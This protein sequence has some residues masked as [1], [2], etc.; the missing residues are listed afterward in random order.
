MTKNIRK[1]FKNIYSQELAILERKSLDIIKSSKH[2]DMPRWRNL[3]DEL[4]DV[5]PSFFELDGNVIKIGQRDEIDDVSYAKLYEILR[6]YMPWRK[7][8]YSIFGINID[9]EWRSDIK[10]DRFKDGISDISG[11]KILDIGAANGYHSLRALGAGAEFVMGVDPTL[12]Y[13]MQFQLL[14]RYLKSD[15]VNVLPVGVDDIP[16]NCGYFDTVFSMG[17][18]Y[19]RRSPFDHLIQIYSFLKSGGELVLETLVVD[20]PQGY[21]LTP[22]DRYAKMSNLWFIPSVETLLNWLKK[23][24]YVDLKVSDISKTTSDEQRVTDWMTFES[25]NDF[26]DPLNKD[27]TVEGYPAP[28]RAVVL[29]KKPQ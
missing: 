19:H 28:R 14:N 11:R 22:R 13:F 9:T 6:Q 17:L 15:K 20:G 21:A 26:L 8:P 23:C 5:N 12:L 24:R 16:Y 2:G 4:P 29:A 7:G 25:L 18:L 3:Y 1:F 10:W 27:I